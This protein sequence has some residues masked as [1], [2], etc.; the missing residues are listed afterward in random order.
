VCPT[1]PKAIY[2]KLETVKARDGSERTLKRP[3]VDLSLCTGCGICETR[4]PVF[5]RAA[6]RCSSVGETRSPKNRI[7][8]SGGRV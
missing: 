1:S 3:Y 8:M 2:F 6:I 7:I 4:C 5:D